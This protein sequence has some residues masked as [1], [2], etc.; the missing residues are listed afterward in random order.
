MVLKYL[1]YYLGIRYIKS[2]R[3]S[4]TQFVTVY[5]YHNKLIINLQCNSFFTPH[6]LYR[7]GQTNKPRNFKQ[8][9]LF[10]LVSVFKTSYLSFYNRGKVSV[11]FYSRISTIEHPS[12][13]TYCLGL[14]DLLG[15][16]F[17]LRRT[18]VDHR[19]Y[20]YLVCLKTFIPLNISNGS[21][22]N[23]KS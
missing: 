10:F 16:Y 21:S 15:V 4:I 6:P 5:P 13:S 11:L 14:V 12:I 2:Q 9:K 19:L 17:R 22:L 20:T 1:L 8:S 3:K 23:K 18:G 7:K